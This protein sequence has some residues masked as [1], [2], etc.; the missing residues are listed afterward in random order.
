[1]DYATENGI[2]G[3]SGH[4]GRNDAV[5]ARAGW[6]P[7]GYKAGK[8][9]KLAFFTADHWP[10]INDAEQVVESVDS[11]ALSIDLLQSIEA[12]IAD[13]LAEALHKR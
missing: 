2:R 12:A 7:G 4:T 6:T 9:L 13:W 11:L 5:L 3:K 1:M 8:V 10:R